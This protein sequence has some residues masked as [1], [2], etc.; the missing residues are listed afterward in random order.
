[1]ATDVAF[2]I[3]VTF[4]NGEAEQYASEQ[5]L[6]CNLEHFDS[7]TA[8]GCAVVD[9]KGRRVRL[10]LDTLELKELRLA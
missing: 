10:K 9:A 5:E 2:P 1:M 3:T 7:E 8:K 6:E 4:E